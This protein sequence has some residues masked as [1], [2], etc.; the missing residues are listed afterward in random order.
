MNLMEKY[1]HYPF[2]V[3][4]QEAKKIQEELRTRVFFRFPFRTDAVERI[5]GVD[6]S[7]DNE[8]HALAAVVIFAYP[9][10]KVIDVV[11]SR[12]RPVFPYVPGFLSF[13]EGPAIEEAFSKIRIAPQIIFFDGQGY[14][15]PRFFGLASH[16]GVLY[17]VPTV[18]VAKKKLVGSGN[19]PRLE[20]GAYTWLIYRGRRVGATLRTRTNV[21]PVFVSPGHCMGLLQAVRWA[22]RVTGKYRIPEPTRLAHMHSRDVE[23]FTGG[24]SI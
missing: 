15:H 11:M 22:M 20:R 19:I 3:D 17:G 24:R 1:V 21:K 2:N 16:M 5:A 23:K 18:G 12:S 7:Y 8:G 13:R 10:L 4:I 6:V 14:A 9:S